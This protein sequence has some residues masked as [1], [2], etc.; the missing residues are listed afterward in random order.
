MTDDR[1]LLY[2]QAPLLQVSSGT[3]RPGGL[4]LTDHA[5]DFCRLPAGSLALDA[6]CGQGVTV[7]HLITCHHLRAVGVDSSSM[8]LHAAHARMT[9]PPLLQ[10][11]GESLPVASGRFNVVLAECTL[12]LMDSDR[13]LAEF[14][15]VLRDD[16][17]LIVTD[18]YARDPRGAEGLRDLPVRSCVAGALPCETIMDL[19]TTHGFTVRRWEDH[20]EALK[21]FAARLI[22]EHG[23]LG[24]FWRCAIPAAGDTIDAA[25]SRA[26]PGYYLLIAQ[27]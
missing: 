2:E 7:E 10:A 26:K 1:V 14:H 4:A 17:W 12:S 23:S 15:R 6:G 24:Q 25:A 18:L 19:V 8:L 21:L 13:A 11:I 22:W 9:S 27:K 20:T 3:I 16:G 5:L